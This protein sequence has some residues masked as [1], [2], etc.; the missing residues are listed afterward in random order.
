MRFG[1]AAITAALLIVPATLSH[2][3][4]IYYFVT[5]GD[6]TTETRVDVAHPNAWTFTPTTDFFMGG[7]MLMMKDMQQTTAAST[8]SIWEGEAQLG[9]FTL[10]NAP[11]ARSFSVIRFSF[12]VDVSLSAGHTYTLRLTSPARDRNNE[13]YYLATASYGFAD[14]AG[15]PMPNDPFHPGPAPVPEPGT[16]TLLAGG[17][18]LL[19]A[20]TSRFAVSKAGITRSRS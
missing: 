19:A 17:A 12:P 2:A 14:A 20:G 15:N 7:G 18:I 13:I 10:S 1:T 9:A 5:S 3:A 16:W 6:A 8:F 11:F 4:P